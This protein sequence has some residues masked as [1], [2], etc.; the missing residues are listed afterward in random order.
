MHEP[1]QPYNDGICGADHALVTSG[2][3][4]KA[5]TVN[6]LTD[7]VTP[8]RAMLAGRLLQELGMFSAKTLASDPS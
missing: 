6:H 3:H 5:T 1:P 4:W 7:F 8:G 2:T